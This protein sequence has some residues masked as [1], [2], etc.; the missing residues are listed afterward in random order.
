MKMKRPDL[1][2]VVVVLT[3]C[4]AVGYAAF[5]HAQDAPV[6]IPVPAADKDNLRALI[7]KQDKIEKQVAE[8]NAQFM[9]LQQQAIAQMQGLQ[10][11]QE[12]QKKAIDAAETQAFAAAKLDPAKY[13]LDEDAMEFTPKPELKAP[14]EPKK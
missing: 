14:A 11:D 4:A 1:T 6:K 12:K 9:K 10:A 2:F 8:L 3:L 13:T 7:H 5:A